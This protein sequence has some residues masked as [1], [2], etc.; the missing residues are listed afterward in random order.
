MSYREYQSKRDREYELAWAR[1][2]PSQRAEMTKAGIH[3]PLVHHDKTSRKQDDEPPHD[4][5]DHTPTLF[6]APQE[7]RRDEFLQR[8]RDK[9]PMASLQVLKACAELFEEEV[10]K[11]AQK[12]R[13]AEAANIVTRVLLVLTGAKKGAEKTEIPALTKVAFYLMTIIG[14]LDAKSQA[15]AA[16]KLGMIRQTFNKAVNEMRDSPHLNG[17]EIFIFGG[18]KEARTA[19]KIRATEDHKNKR[20]CNQN[21]PPQTSFLAQLR[22]RMAA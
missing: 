20:L 5:L 11:P 12:L 16:A 6:L 8:L 15:A 9:V 22:S 2:T 10:E 4:P 3:G 14:I 19:A 7:S 21:Q 13:Q 1:L 17:L 18:T